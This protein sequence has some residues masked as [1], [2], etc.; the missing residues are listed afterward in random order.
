MRDTQATTTQNA[1]MHKHNRL[2][3]NAGHLQR[4]RSCAARVL[5]AGDLQGQS[6][7]HNSAALPKAF[8]WCHSSEF[9]RVKAAGEEG[10]REQTE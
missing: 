3:S 7:L 4:S 1:Q 5:A 10:R 2:G 6:V 9:S 8:A